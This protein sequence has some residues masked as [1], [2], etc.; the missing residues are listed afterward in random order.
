MDGR[1]DQ[2]T[3]TSLALFDFLDECCL[4]AC[5]SACPTEPHAQKTARLLA[6]RC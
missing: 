3:C 1:P 4:D 6:C 2:E 5:S